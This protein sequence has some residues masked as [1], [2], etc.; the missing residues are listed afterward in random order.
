MNEFA[1]DTS[2]FDENGRKFSKQVK[3]TGER[4]K[5]L[6]TSN[7]YFSHSVFKSLELQTRKNMGLFGKGL[8][9]IFRY[10]YSTIDI[11]EAKCI[12]VC[13][14]SS[15]RVPRVKVCLY[16]WALLQLAPIFCCLLTIYQKKKCNNYLYIHGT[17]YFEFLFF[18][19][20]FRNIRILGMTS[21]FPR[22]GYSLVS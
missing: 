10:A 4:K 12:T 8:K 13:V 3:N 19:S 18:S 20:V 5:L 14:N 22:I 21:F 6:V 15:G 16:I 7:F 11:A 2:K 1:E 17:A 9:Q